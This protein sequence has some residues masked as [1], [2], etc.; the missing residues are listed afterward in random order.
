[1]QWQRKACISVTEHKFR[2]LNIFQ[3]LCFLLNIWRRYTKIGRH[4]DRQ[5]RDGSKE[6][7]L[8]QDS[9]RETSKSSV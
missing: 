1:M 2:Q 4:T 3:L 7:L 8:P 9:L 6:Q 5:M